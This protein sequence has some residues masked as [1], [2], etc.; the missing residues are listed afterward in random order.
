MLTG[1]DTG[2]IVTASFNRTNNTNDTALLANTRYF[3]VFCGRNARLGQ[4]AMGDVKSF[5]TQGDSTAL[6][7]SA[8]IDITNQGATFIGTLLRASGSIE[9]WFIRVDGDVT[10]DNDRCGSGDRL[11]SESLTAVGDTNV[12]TLDGLSSASSHTVGFCSEGESGE[13]FLAGQT[14]FTTL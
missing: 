14:G 7:I 13:A 11:N 8:P 5:I 10:L 2:D 3:Y 1:R 6:S 9:T 12:I 4:T